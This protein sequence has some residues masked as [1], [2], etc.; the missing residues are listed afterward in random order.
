[1]G[2]RRISNKV[3]GLPEHGT[4]LEDGLLPEVGLVGAHL[5]AGHHGHF[6]SGGFVLDPGRNTYLEGESRK[7][8]VE[9][10][11]E[12]QRNSPG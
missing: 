7:W 4:L 9:D 5:V 3:K 8:L 2:F 10:E 12:R 1:M 6:I 11:E